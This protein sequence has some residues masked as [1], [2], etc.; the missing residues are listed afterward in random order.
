MAIDLLSIQPH[1]VSRDLSGYITYIYG[2]GGVGKT[3][4][5]TKAPGALLLATEKGYNALPGVIPQ[6]I[7]SWSE[8]KQVL[9]ELKKPEVKQRFKTVIVDTIDLA[10]T[11]CEKYVCAQNDVEK[12]GEIPYGQGW[13]LLKREFEETFRAI[14]QHGYAIFF[15]SHDKD[16]LFKREDGT[17][18]NQIVPSC[19]STCG[20]I[21]KNMVD[22]M[23]YAHQKIV[24]GVPKRLLTFR[25]LDG[26]IDCK[27]RFRY[28]PDFVE[29]GY[30]NLIAALNEAIDKEAE[31]TQ[32]AYVTDE[33]VVI[34]QR[35]IKPYTELVE[36]FQ[37][38]TKKLMA[39][40]GADFAT[41]ITA[42]VEK[43]LGKGKKV[44][45]CTDRQAEV[46]D[47]IVN[48]LKAL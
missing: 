13:T 33:R 27:S 12:I 3:T 36:E 5:A 15:I 39:E 40:R 1:K 42:I 21:I 43:H 10:A 31:E 6:D 24:D 2:K 9:R 26:S 16:K 37:S 44:S 8:M 38:I 7:T 48:E 45:E 23:A 47:L 18:Y 32:N 4:L 46:I 29:L 35:E 22:I 11:M 41:R 34:V 20:E 17:E 14:A 19:S 25:S 28:M 30:D